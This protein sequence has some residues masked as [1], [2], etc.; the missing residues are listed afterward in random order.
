MD[1]RTPGNFKKISCEHE[2]Y[3]AHDKLGISAGLDPSAVATAVKDIIEQFLA[4]RPQ[5][6]FNGTIY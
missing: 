2:V 1:A 4:V 6:N 5:R 3:T